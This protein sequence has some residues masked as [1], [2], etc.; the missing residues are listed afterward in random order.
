ME[1]RFAGSTVLSLTLAQIEEL[2]VGN[3]KPLGRARL[4]DDGAQL[5]KVVALELTQALEVSVGHG[6]DVE[7]E[8]AWPLVGQALGAALSAPYGEL[9]SGTGI[10]A[11]I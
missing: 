5:S 11:Q 7:S 2:Q 10:V 4:G 8:S 1:P 6:E 9:L 3:D